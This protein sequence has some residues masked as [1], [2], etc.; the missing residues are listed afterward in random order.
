MIRPGSL[1]RSQIVGRSGRGRGGSVDGDLSSYCTLSLVVGE[2]EG[3]DPLIIGE[4]TGVISGG[5]NS[6]GGDG[7]RKLLGSWHGV[8]RC[9][10]RGLG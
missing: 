7:P 10:L 8:T 2:A 3:E 6:Q 4:R 9:M 5:V 1:Q